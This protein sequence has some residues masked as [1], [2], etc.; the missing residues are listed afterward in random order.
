[1]LPM[2]V[3]LVSIPASPSR[4]AP[5]PNAEECAERAR[6]VNDRAKSQ[7][8]PLPP[9]RFLPRH[10]TTI[11]RFFP[12][13]A[14]IRSQLAS[15]THSIPASGSLGLQLLGTSPRSLSILYCTTHTTYTKLCKAT[16]GLSLS[17]FCF[18]EG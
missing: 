12:I 11:D 4:Q 17:L 6:R 9:L 14:S 5:V 10:T 18:P 3:M 8:S 2:L 13:T 1:M 16:S 15:K 7:K